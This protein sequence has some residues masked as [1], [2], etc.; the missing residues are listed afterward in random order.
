M[1]KIIAEHFQGTIDGQPFLNDLICSRIK[2]IV[3]DR[4]NV[5]FGLLS[6]KISLAYGNESII[7]DDVVSKMK[8][9]RQRRQSL[10][11]SFN[12]V[13]SMSVW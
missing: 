10:L 13:S 8:A 7:L 4:I 11:S 5:R 9:R 6:P 12:M 3:E 1:E 2:F